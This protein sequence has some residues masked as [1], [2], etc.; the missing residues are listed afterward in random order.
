[1][2]ITMYA[3]YFIV[4]GVMDL[5]FIFIKNNASY[6]IFKMATEDLVCKSR[7]PI[8]LH[9]YYLNR[10]TD[11]GKKRIVHVCRMYDNVNTVIKSSAHSSL[12]DLPILLTPAASHF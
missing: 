2:K 12:I 9:V 3:K 4:Y 1:M 6:Y 8:I 10:A 7:I 5:S 11:F